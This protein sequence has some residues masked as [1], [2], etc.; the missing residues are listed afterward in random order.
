MPCDKHPICFGTNG[1][2]MLVTTVLWLRCIDNS[3]TSELKYR[4]YADITSSTDYINIVLINT[5]I[6][7]LPPTNFKVVLINPIAERIKG[8]GAAKFPKRYGI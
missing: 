2:D 7:A 8:T 1:I 6:K 3:T 5:H 4:F